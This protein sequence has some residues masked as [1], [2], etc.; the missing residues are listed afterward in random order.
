LRR[1]LWYAATVFISS[2]CLL[3]LEIVA[4]RLL[5]P[6]VGVSLYT[7]TAIIGVILAGLSLGNWLGGVWADRGGGEHAVGFTLLA[8]GIASLGILLL[9]TWIAPLVNDR[10]FGLLGASFV[11]VLTLFF[12]PAVLLGVITPMLTTLALQLRLRTGRVVGTL[13]ALA[14]L[15]SI[16]GTFLTGYLLI[17]YLG[18][19]AVVFGTAL[20]LIGLGL[21]FLRGR[22]RGGTA[23]VVLGL[24][25]LLWFGWERGAFSNPCQRESS[26]FC[27]R[28]I[29]SSDD[30]PYGEA[31]SLIL[32]HLLHGTNHRQDPKLLIA[33]YVHLL[34]E[35]LNDALRRGQVDTPRVFFGGGGAYTQP[36]AVAARFPGA[37][38]VVAEIDPTV[39]E[40]ARESL[41]LRTDQLHVQHTDARL[42]LAGFAGSYFDAVVT[43]VFKDVAVPHHLVTEE[44]AMLVHDRL[45][46]GGLYVLNVVD[47]FPDARF[48]KSLVK[49]LN[50]VFRHVHLFLHELPEQAQRVTL[51]IAAS[52]EYLP[53]EIVHSRS[54]LRRRWFRITEPL[55]ATGTPL[56]S[57]PVLRDDHAPVERLISTLLVGHA[58]R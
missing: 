5:A 9:L 7:W 12:L 19:R 2:A 42:A 29:D 4:G 17:Q 55:L 51:V 36:R 54:G 27:I 10:H 25:P 28:V 18:T 23:L 11:L 52:D 46:S 37:E 56:A 22:L 43:D 58:G 14:A 38:V 47:M 45:R 24:V 30:A 31:R 44:Y 48:A 41:Y 53:E 6:Y 8:A 35:L 49:T 20:T 15:G 3:V 1:L 13:H 34:D 57:L 21:P 32:D 16:C 40:V 50:R 33:P 39:T 26:Y